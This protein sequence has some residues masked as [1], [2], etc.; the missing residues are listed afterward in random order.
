MTS[1]IDLTSL[2]APLLLRKHN[3]QW[4]YNTA[5]ASEPCSNSAEGLWM[6]YTD[7]ENEIIEDAFQSNKTEVEIDDD[8]T[9]NIDCQLQYNKLDQSDIRSIKR[10]QLQLNCSDFR[11]LR[12]ERFSLPITLVSLSFESS[13]TSHI[14]EF[15]CPF[16]MREA[17]SFP[18]VYYDVHLEHTSKTLANV[19][20]EIAYGIKIEGTNFGKPKEGEWLSLQLYNLKHFG[21]DIKADEDTVYIPDEIGQT[22]VFIYTKDVFGIN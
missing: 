12:E 15:L 4:Y 9:V 19:V 10:E 11:H 6:E 20:E 1:T 16:N 3:F 8:I 5:T 7:I 21:N 2:T 13:S 14:D 22:C 17:R 18:S